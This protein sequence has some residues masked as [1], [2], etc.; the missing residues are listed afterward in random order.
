MVAESVPVSVQ[1][2]GA[3]RGLLLTHAVEHRR[4]RRKLGAEAF[5]IVGVHALV[6]FFK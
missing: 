3:M 2:P 1:Q 4:R 5:G 6:L